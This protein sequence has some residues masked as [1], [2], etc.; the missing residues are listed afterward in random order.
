MKIDYKNRSILLSYAYEPN[1]QKDVELYFD[2]FD[3]VLYFTDLNGGLFLADGSPYTPSAIPD[4]NRIVNM[5]IDGSA[6]NNEDGYDS[7]Y[8]RVYV[9]FFNK[10]KTSSINVDNFLLGDSK[11]L[12]VWN[13]FDPSTSGYQVVIAASEPLYDGFDPW[14]LTATVENEAGDINTLVEQIGYRL[15]YKRF[16]DNDALCSFVE[17]GF[18]N[19]DIRLEGEL[20][21]SQ[22]SGGFFSK[23]GKQNLNEAPSVY[24]VEPYSYVMVIGGEPFV[25]GDYYV[26]N[27]GSVQQ[28]LLAQL[29]IDFCD[30]YPVV[31]DTCVAGENVRLFN[32]SSF[33]QYELC[34]Y[35]SSIDQNIENV[36]YNGTLYYNPQDNLTYKDDEFTILADA[37]FYLW[38]WFV[39]CVGSVPY[40]QVINGQGEETGW[41]PAS[42]SLPPLGGVVNCDGAT[43]Q[44]F[45][46]FFNCS[47]SCVVF[48][49]A[50]SICSDFQGVG[51]GTLYYRDGDGKCFYDEG[52]TQLS[53]GYAAFYDAG[54]WYISYFNDNGNQVDTVSLTT[55]CG[56]LPS[57]QAY[58]IL[59]DLTESCSY[60]ATNNPPVYNGVGYIDTSFSPPRFFQ[61][62]DGV[63]PVEDGL[64]FVVNPYDIANNDFNLFTIGGN[65]GAIVG[66]IQ[67]PTTY[68]DTYIPVVLSFSA[69]STAYVSGSAACVYYNDNE[70]V[71]EWNTTI[72]KKEDNTWWINDEFE[73]V[74]DATYIVNFI[75]DK[76]GATRLLTLV[77]QFQVE[78]EIASTYCNPA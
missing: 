22:I 45:P 34:D 11:P 63:T 26:Q 35:W 32:G 71:I 1:G 64:Y 66:S 74:E 8:G 16:A 38:C 10:I 9:N 18:D 13:S 73:P 60:L 37:G 78:N 76:Y 7:P 68:C 62:K 24:Y 56:V 47:E 31:S 53:T 29:A 30:C 36:T 39:P 5:V 55:E 65:E 75:Y 6:I 72:Y 12:G 48:E 44:E 67:N 3:K 51:N 15:T 25:E 23:D 54:F 70:G 19:D 49:D 20:A 69:S 57:A 28:G 40:L 14:L 33:D 17:G 52:L 58:G 46:A 43:Y 4:G 21:Y 59:T 2:R 27:E 41:Y 61:D 50:S 42:T 77:D